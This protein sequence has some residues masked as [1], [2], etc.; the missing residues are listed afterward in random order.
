MDPIVNNTTKYVQTV[1]IIKFNNACQCVE[2]G[3]VYSKFQKE[4]T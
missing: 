1:S 4:V 3:E 2:G